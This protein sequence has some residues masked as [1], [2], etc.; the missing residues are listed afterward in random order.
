MHVYTHRYQRRAAFTK[1]N[2][3]RTRSKNAP[4][5]QQMGRA[6]TATKHDSPWLAMFSI[7]Q[8]D[9][10]Y[11]LVHSSRARKRN[12]S[13]YHPQRLET[14]FKNFLF[15]KKKLTQLNKFDLKKRL[16]CLNGNTV[17]VDAHV[18]LKI[19]DLERLS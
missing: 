3:P 6:Q 7:I 9:R 8:S 14:F 19:E 2:G 16:F 17:R 1:G 5:Y 13:S 4:G 10:S 18:F 12:F 11:L 15:R